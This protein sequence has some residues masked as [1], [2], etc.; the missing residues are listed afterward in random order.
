MVESEQMK[1][2]VNKEEDDLVA[3]SVAALKRLAASLIVGDEDFA[4]DP[5]APL[6]PFRGTPPAPLGR[7]VL[8]GEGQDVGEAVLSAVVAIDGLHLFGAD[9]GDG[10]E[11]NP[12]APLWRGVLRK[13]K[14]DGVCGTVRQSQREALPPFEYRLV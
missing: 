13:G 5:P 9:E 12:P 1:Q 8:Q 4:H 2:A 3:G 11:P 6:P 7:G 10:D 14:G